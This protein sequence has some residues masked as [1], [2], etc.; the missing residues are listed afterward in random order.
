[1]L[2]HFSWRLWCITIWPLEILPVIF[3]QCLYI[4]ICFKTKPNYWSPVPTIIVVDSRFKSSVFLKK[5]RVLKKG[6]VFWIFKLWVINNFDVYLDLVNASVSDSALNVV[7]KW[8]RRVAKGQWN[9]G[10]NLHANHTWI[11][12]KASLDYFLVRNSPY[13]LPYHSYGVWFWEFGFGSTYNP[14]I[15]IFLNSQHL[16]AWYCIDIARRNFVLVTHGS[17]RVKG[18]TVL[19]VNTASICPNNFL[20]V[21]FSTGVPPQLYAQRFVT[22]Q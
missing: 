16:S 19:V 3:N 4:Y 20:I 9:I 21:P 13:C 2:V 15:D 8:K 1:M 14:V 18:L 22:G 10:K 12:H 6:Y 7:F 11:T 5:I 17:E